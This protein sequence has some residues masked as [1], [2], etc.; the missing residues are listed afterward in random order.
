MSTQP[1]VV[2]STI[3]TGTPA[4]LKITLIW[5]K[6]NRSLSTAP[7]P[8]QANVGDMIQFSSADGPVRVVFLSPFGDSTIEMKDAEIRTISVSGF[9]HFR[10]FITPK[11]ET[12]EVPSASGGVIDIQP[13]P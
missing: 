3:G 8:A 9:Y 4:P 13:H 7:A 2:P 12:N 5:D 10:C 6:P 11:G 1:Q